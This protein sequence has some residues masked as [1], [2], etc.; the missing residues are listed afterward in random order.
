MAVPPNTPKVARFISLGSEPYFIRYN[1]QL[2][3]VVYA[4]ETAEVRYRIWSSEGSTGAI[5][6][7]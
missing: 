5:P 6:Q 7:G 4:P 2:P 3:I 1:S